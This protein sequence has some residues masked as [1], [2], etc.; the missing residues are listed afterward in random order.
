MYVHVLL[1]KGFTDFT[2]SY[3][4]V[5]ERYGELNKYIANTVNYKSYVGEKFRGSLDFII[6]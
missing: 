1:N 3:R 4:L 6:M 5:I 2:K